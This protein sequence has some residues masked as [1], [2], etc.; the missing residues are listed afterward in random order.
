M[1]RK[2][3]TRLIYPKPPGDP[4]LE[5]GE[6]GTELNERLYEVHSHAQMTMG[7]HNADRRNIIREKSM[8]DNLIQEI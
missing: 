1:E 4:R 3:H 7:K 8:E 6:I 5:L 2:R